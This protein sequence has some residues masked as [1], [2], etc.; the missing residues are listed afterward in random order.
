MKQ[1]VITMLQTNKEIKTEMQRNGHLRINANEC[2]YT[3]DKK[4]SL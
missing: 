2:G 3:E 1:F 4:N